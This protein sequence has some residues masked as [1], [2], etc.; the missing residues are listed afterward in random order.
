MLR[1]IGSRLATL[2][3]SKWKLL[4]YASVFSLRKFIFIGKRLHSGSIIHRSAGRLNFKKLVAGAWRTIKPHK[5]LCFCLINNGTRWVAD[6]GRR[7]AVCYFDSP[8]YDHTSD[9]FFLLPCAV[10]P[11]SN[12]CMGM[13]MSSNVQSS[14]L[15]RSLLGYY[16]YHMCIRWNWKKLWNILICLKFKPTQSYLIHMDWETY[17]Q[18]PATNFWFRDWE[19]LQ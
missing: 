18:A 7:P 8:Q 1:Y 3:S 5:W 9:S 13:I 19:Q 16:S 12:P 4:Y 17:K 15:G 10:I 6:N 2:G 11:I 14:Y